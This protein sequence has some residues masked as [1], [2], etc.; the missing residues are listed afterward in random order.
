MSFSNFLSPHLAIPRPCVAMLKPP[1]SVC[2]FISD[3]T[4]S[5][6]GLLHTL[7][8]EENTKKRKKIDQKVGKIVLMKVKELELFSLEEGNCWVV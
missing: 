1:F 7:E 6:V 3:F 2:L 5:S 4:F 8:Q